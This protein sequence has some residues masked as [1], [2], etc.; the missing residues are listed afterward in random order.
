MKV[1]IIGSGGREH[2]IAWKISKSD[3]AEKI[4]T[5]PGNPGISELAECKN[6]GIKRENFNQIISFVEE[7]DIDFTIVGPEA[8]L[9]DGIVDFFNERGHKIFGPDTKGAILEG[10][11]VFTKNLCKKYE[12]P[13]PESNNFKRSERQKANSYIS[14]LKDDKFPIVIKVDG[15]AAGKGVI[16]AQNKEEALH[17]VD[18]CFLENIFGDSGNNIVIEDFIKGFELSL[19]SLCDGRNVIPMVLAQDY[20]KIFDCDMGKNTGGMGSYCPVPF[21][22]DDLYNK[23]LNRI[24]Y[25]TYNALLK[26]GI[27]YKGILYG[28]IIVEK[29]Q[30]YLLEYNCR[31]GDPETQSILPRLNN[32][33][34]DLLVK[35]AGGEL[36]NEKLSWA[37][38]KCVCVIMA[39]KG[40]PES[41]SSGDIIEGLDALK[42]N[43]DINVFHAGTRCQNGN[44]AT[45]G[46]RVLGIVSSAP[47]FKEA[48]SKIYSVIDRIKFDGMQY[49]KDIA[50]RVEEE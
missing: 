32:D 18:Q 20:K 22:S 12:I 38:S 28:G 1:L 2:C 45:A 48:R 19:L 43:K 3:F 25:P 29:G 37:D 23:I 46:G 24:I 9:V 13:T 36:S 8:P 5:I 49:R 15:L 10:S 21:V 40:Y 42:N 31:F 17:T 41:S 4:Y 47:S 11:K 30:P 44:I 33:L 7:K 34:L 14:N 27:I 39:S 26:E 50:L 35:C 16:I 6:I